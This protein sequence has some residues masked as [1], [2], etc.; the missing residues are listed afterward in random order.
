MQIKIIQITINEAIWSNPAYF[1]LIHIKQGIGKHLLYKKLF[2]NI[3][4]Y[5]SLILI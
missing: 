3:Y 4:Q 1:F 5:K 2:C